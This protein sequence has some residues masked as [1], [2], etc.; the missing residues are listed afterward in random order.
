M[1]RRVDPH[2]EEA[3]VLVEFAVVFLL[4][5]TLLWGLIS[6]GVIFAAQQTITHAAA[7]AARATVGQTTRDAAKDIAVA[8]ATEQLEWLGTAGEPDRDD[9]T[10]GACPAPSTGDTC[11]FVEYT[12]PWATDPIVPPLLDIGVP[13]VLTGTAVVVWEGL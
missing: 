12:Y 10:F 13:H 5:V 4:F 1:R 6:Y 3:A 9:V 7:E 2:N 8:T 11:A